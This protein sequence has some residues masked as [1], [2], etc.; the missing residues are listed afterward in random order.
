MKCAM[1]I[2]LLLTTVSAFAEDKPAQEPADL[3]KIRKLYETKV[4]AAVDPITAAYVKKLDE[5][6]KAYGAKGDLESAQAVQKEIE[7]MST[8]KPAMTLV[9]KWTWAGGIA[10]FQKDGSG[11]CGNSTS[12]WKCLDKKAHKYQIVWAAGVTDWVQISSDGTTIFLKNNSGHTYT[13]QRLPSD[14]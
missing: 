7:S 6:K 10:E 4:K 8:T 3:V 1:L 5:M 2:V 12:K 9:G 11:K 13:F 14:E